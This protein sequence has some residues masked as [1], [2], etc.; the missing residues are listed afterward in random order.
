MYLQT[1]QR[2]SFLSSSARHFNTLPRDVVNCLSQ[3]V[4]KTYLPRTPENLIWSLTF[5]RRVDQMIS[6]CLSHSR[7][8]HGSEIKRAAIYHSVKP[9]QWLTRYGDHIH[10]V[11]SDQVSEIILHICFL[12]IMW[13]VPLLF[14]GSCVLR[15]SLVL[16]TTLI[17]GLTPW[18]LLRCLGVT[19]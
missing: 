19:V 15:R 13:G 12:Q 5:N 8:F 6:V 17:Q 7:L 11:Q 18:F 10:Y 2:F 4:M 16:S 3:E 1:R 9:S 14:A